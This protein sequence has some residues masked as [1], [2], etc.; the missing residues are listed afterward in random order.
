LRPIKARERVQLAGLP[1]RPLLFGIVSPP[2]RSAGKREFG[3]Q[4]LTITSPVWTHPG[5]CTCSGSAGCRRRTGDLVSFKFRL[6]AAEP[7]ARSLIGPLS[8]C[9]SRCP[10]LGTLVGN[11]GNRR[12]FNLKP[13]DPFATPA[14]VVICR[15]PRLTIADAPIGMGFAGIANSFCKSSLSRLHCER[16]LHLPR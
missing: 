1:C 9:V 10:E 14:S 3:Q 12:L 2:G 6:P 5:L 4:P 15:L 16:N 8:N 7:G 11:R 13:T